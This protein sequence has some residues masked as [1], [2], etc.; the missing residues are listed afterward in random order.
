MKQ[1]QVQTDGH[2]RRALGFAQAELRAAED[3][4]RLEGYGALYNQRT[5]ELPWWDEEISAGAFDGALGDDVL[6]SVDHN[7]Q[8]LLGRTR[9]KT[10]RV[11]AD[12]TGLGFSVELP[13][14]SVARDLCEQ[15]K[16]GDIFGASFV[17]D[18]AEQEWV[19]REGERDLRRITRFAAVYEV[20]PVA[21]PAYLATEVQL[22]S[23]DTWRAERAAPSAAEQ[24]AQL[25]R[26]IDLKRAWS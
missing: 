2:E 25:Q 12:D 5:T 3:G 15:I 8:R 13:D 21:M 11:W 4:S 16:R 23:L 14:T 6:V 20:G 18:V 7:V 17:F 24:R 10:A 1:F 9:S 26:R 22:R 19:E